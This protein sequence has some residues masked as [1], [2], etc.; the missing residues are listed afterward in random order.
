LNRDVVAV[1]LDAIVVGEDEDK[2]GIDRAMQEPGRRRYREVNTLWKAR[3][4]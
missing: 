1:V 2:V 4:H 3:E